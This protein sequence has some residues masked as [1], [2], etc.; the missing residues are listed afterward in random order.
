MVL[1]RH[2]CGV[3]GARWELWGRNIYQIC[4]PC[5]LPPPL[6]CHCNWN[7]SIFCS[8]SSF[9]IV[10]SDVLALGI[11][12]GVVENPSPETFKVNTSLIPHIPDPPTLMVERWKSQRHHVCPPLQSCPS[13]GNQTPSSDPRE[14]RGCKDNVPV[15]V[16]GW[17]SSDTVVFIVTIYNQPH[18]GHLSTLRFTVDHIYEG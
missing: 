16:P 2:N 11:S 12:L 5:S 7:L 13:Q 4:L 9:I 10:M 17:Y 1:S 8:V 18:S 6:R 3:R 14:P 15:Q